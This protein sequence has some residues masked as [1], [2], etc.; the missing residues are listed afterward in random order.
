MLIQPGVGLFYKAL[1]G[2][3]GLKEIA[4]F[5][6]IRSLLSGLRVEERRRELR[7]SRLGA[8]VLG[9]LHCILVITTDHCSGFCC[10]VTGWLV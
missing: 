4:G 10:R 9:I 1:R 8:R 6:R 5:S 2:L 7:E 3:K